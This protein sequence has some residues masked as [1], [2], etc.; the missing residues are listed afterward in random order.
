MRRAV[1]SDAVPVTEL[2]IRARHAAMPVIPAYVHRDEEVG[3]W[4]ASNVILLQETW[5]A[6]TEQGLIGMISLGECWIEQLYVD[7][8][9][10][11][12]GIGSMFIRLAQERYPQ[13]L[14][15][16]CFESNLGARRFYERHG[17]VEAE[18]TDGRR[19]EEGSPDI[20]Y[21]WSAHVQE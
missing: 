19:N 14:Q 17:F 1:G 5:V 20:R 6:E 3:G 8:E 11:G 21:Q 18:R 16:W 4:I 9:W 2:W 10:T 15:L 13:G 12:R 7:P